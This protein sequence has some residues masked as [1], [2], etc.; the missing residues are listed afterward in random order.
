MPFLARPCV[1]GT[2][3][4]ILALV[5]TTAEAAD[6]TM[7]WD[8]GSIYNRVNMA[9]LGDGYTA[10]EISTT[11]EEH[12]DLMLNYMFFAGQDPFPRYR[13]F[14]NVYRVDVVSNESGADVPP[15]GIF[16]DTA[17]D[18]SYYYDG[19]TERLLYINT[20][21][22][23]AVLSDA[24]L[25]GMPFPDVPLVTVNDA[26]YGGGG[27]Q[28]AVWA[29]GNV[30]A[31]EVALH[32]LGHSFGG[33][34]DEYGGNPGVYPGGEPSDPNL[35]TSPGGEKWQHWL[36]YD[37]PG[38]GVIGAYEGGDHYDQGIFRP[39]FNSKMRSL[40]WPFDAIA[41]EEFILQIYQRV[42]PLDAWS[43]N[44][45][46]L[47]GSEPLWVDVVD[48]DV[49]R[50]N[51]YVNDQ[52]VPDATG[53]SF[54]LSDYGFGAG[55]YTIRAFAYDDT[56]WVRKNTQSMTEEVTWTV[57]AVPEPGTLVLLLTGLVLLACNGGRLSK[58]RA[59]YGTPRGE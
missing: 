24:F 47:D 50:V 33:L 40:G 51:W 27:G 34:G 39:S 56:D 10:D 59:A 53:Q 1:A 23:G 37:Q 25:A 52:L 20:S 12:V 42:R 2:A 31:P 54:L 3:A 49:I 29:G 26:R 5:S 44:F 43:P 48:P 7:L 36:G 4:L 45:G 32:E 28:Y 15:L 13:N 14:F 38:I 19:T 16:R 8:N 58:R 57:I 35:T 21:K 11:Y 18:A 46:V 17:L 6:F 30:W 22:A 55:E 41:R 9:L